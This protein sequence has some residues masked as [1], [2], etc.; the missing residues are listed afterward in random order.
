MKT[1]STVLSVLAAGLLSAAAAA[2]DTEYDI[3]IVEYPGALGTDIF[4]INDRGQ[5][6]GNGQFADTNLP[7]VYDSKKQTFTPI[8]PL[9]GYSRTGLLGISD[10]GTLVGSVVSEDGLTTEGLIIDK[11]GNATVFAHPEALSF[12]QARAVNNTG[13]VSGYRDLEGDFFTENWGFIYDSRTGEFT[14]IVPSLFTIAQGI[15]N[16]GEVVG[17]AI[18]FGSDAPCPA[19]PAA[20]V[21][22]GWVR[23]TDGTV[24]YFTVNGGGTSARG[25][26]D[27]G[28]I[29]GFVF[30]PDGVK[31][32]VTDSD[33]APCQDISI[34]DEDLLVV[35][36]ASQT[37]GASISNAGVVAGGAALVDGFVGFVATPKP[38][39]GKKK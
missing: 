26:A 22:F 5:A 30:T 17:S 16:K 31:A 7:F 24:T 34:A 4:G 35:E 39:K 25:L 14:D 28:R 13:L 29:S 32:F 9:T 21:R 8:A 38:P 19:D 11:Q 6:V 37:I 12:T 15:N 10:P 3:Q 33:I 20:I 36:D 2:A 23:A 18:F 1:T 27:N